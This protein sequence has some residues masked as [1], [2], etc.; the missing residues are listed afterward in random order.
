MT[1][2]RSWYGSISGPGALVSMVKASPT[3]G[4][5]RQMPAIQ[6]HGWPR[7]VN[8]LELLGLLLATP[9]ISLPKSVSGYIT[10]TF[11]LPCRGHQVVDARADLIDVC[12]RA[13]G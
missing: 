2:C 1:I 12:R 5:L 7:L 8:S 10:Q 13:A 3:S 6:N 11:F 4:V 9:R